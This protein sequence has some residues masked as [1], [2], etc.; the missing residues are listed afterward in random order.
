MAPGW[1][2]AKHGQQ[3]RNTLQTYVYPHIGDRLVADI[4]LADVRAVLDPIWTAKTETAKRVQSRMAKV[5]NWAK[6]HGFRQ[7]PN[8]AEWKG[9][10]DAILS[11][12]SKVAKVVHHAALPYG[13]AHDFIKR[14]RAMAGMGPRALEFAI[15]TAARSGEVRG[16]TWAEI[17]LEQ[18]VWIVP[19]DRMKAKR[20]HRVP[21]AD[22]A[23]QLLRDLP[24]MSG[25]DLIFPSSKNTP[26]SDNTLGAVLERMQEPV[27]AHGFRSTFRD[28]AQEC[29]AFGDLAEAA[30]AHQVQNKV[31]AA[32]RRGD[33]F[34]KRRVMMD[35]W[36][37]FLNGHAGKGNVVPLHHAA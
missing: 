28:W 31:E 2:N 14:L 1:K 11:A 18:K 15:L 7:G 30:L 4:T 35:E 32:Y 19:A 16:A 20:E 37:K 36:A 17:D 21:L 9:N 5:L 23:V 34:N 6:V 24:R 29:T 27:T 12:P 13:K 33:L 3:W 25:T 8:P 22:D 26:L 10:L